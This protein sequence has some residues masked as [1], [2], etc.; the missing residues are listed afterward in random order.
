MK[1]I[2]WAYVIGACSSVAGVTAL[3]PT[4]GI[5]GAVSAIY[6]SELTMIIF[7][8]AGTA[9]EKINSPTGTKNGIP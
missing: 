2:G 8:S 1:L 3:V 6:L 5:S 7:L 4:S 9:K